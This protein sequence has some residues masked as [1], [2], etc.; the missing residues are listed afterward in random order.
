MNSHNSLSKKTT[1]HRRTIRGRALALLSSMLA[2]APVVTPTNTSAA[3]RG[4]PQTITR[5]A[6][7]PVKTPA[8]APAMSGTALGQLLAMRNGGDE[9][10]RDPGCPPH[11]WGQSAECRRM[12]RKNKFIKR[13]VGAAR[14]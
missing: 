9:L 2:L 1:E 3:E 11:I 6:N 13:G 5:Q 14:C 7:R 12:V 8:Q 10:F 4:A